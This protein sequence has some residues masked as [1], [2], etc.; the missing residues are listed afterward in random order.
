MWSTP[1]VSAV[2]VGEGGVGVLP[3]DW[4]SEELDDDGVD[5]A[6]PEEPEVF[7]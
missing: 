7:G 5:A 3:P 4:P 2:T 6:P 1:N